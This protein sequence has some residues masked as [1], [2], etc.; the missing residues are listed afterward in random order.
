M[1]PMFHSSTGSTVVA[2]TTTTR[3]PFHELSA[4]KAQYEETLGWRVSVDAGYRRLVMHVGGR[5]DAIILPVR[6]AERA[7]AE[8]RFAM[9]DGPV[10]APGG[11]WLTFLTT[12]T[13]AANPCLPLE[14]RQARAQLIPRE[15]QIIIPRSLTAQDIPRDWRWMVAPRPH[16][17]LPP[18]CAV[19]AAARRAARW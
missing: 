16:R 5:M 6:L 11:Q 12:R 15:G 17:A 7:L 2:M 3:N 8:L 9:L 4:V 18:W 13:A 10:A 19:V 14:L 1:R